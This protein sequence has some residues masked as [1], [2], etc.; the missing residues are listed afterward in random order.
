MS[1]PD[2]TALRTGRPDCPSDL[3]LD[4]LQAGE[5]PRERA[6]EAERH[7]AGCAD[8]GARMAERRAGFGAI[9]GV[10]PRVMLARIR[11][12]LDRPASLS[13]RL[14][15]GFR[16]L[17]A[18]LAVVAAAAVAFVVVTR[19]QVQQPSLDTRP[20]GSLALH[21]FR[22]AGDHAEE[23]VSGGAFAPRDRL[24]FTVDLPEE[25]YVTVLGI[26]SSGALYTAWP[27]EPGTETR[28][29]AGTGIELS[30]AVSLDAK[31]GRE[32]F[33]LVHCPVKVGPPHCTSS[34]AG[35]A[36]V[37][38]AGCESTPFLMEKGP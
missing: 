35:A 20:K 15:G 27:L 28:F 3:T 14:L 5:L 6:Q 19:E 10:D 37:C 31:P 18:P 29:A 11:T 34:G 1:L 2:F 8:C 9:E 12:G 17:F 16:R 38:P 36:P 22:L 32:T 21:V 33:H 4:R 30:G 23:M 25:G 13:E 7:I 24:R 26:E